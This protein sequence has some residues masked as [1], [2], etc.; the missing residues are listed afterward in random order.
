MKWILLIVTAEEVP[1]LLLVLLR[2][3]DFEHNYL[4]QI[5]H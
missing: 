3:V 1:K 4:A 5:P 2:L